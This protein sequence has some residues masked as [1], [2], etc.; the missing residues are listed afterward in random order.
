MLI[1]ERLVGEEGRQRGGG[2]G[3]KIDFK[4]PKRERERDCG[5]HLW[6]NT[7]RLVLFLCCSN[8]KKKPN[9]Q[10]DRATRGSG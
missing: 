1:R 9:T 4:D 8:R 2:G 7:A 10:R 5:T 3:R 6:P